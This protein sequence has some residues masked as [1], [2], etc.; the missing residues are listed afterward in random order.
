MT[1]VS[2]RAQELCESRGCRL[3]LPVPNNFYGLC[4]RKTTLNFNSIIR[5]KTAGILQR[6]ATKRV[7]SAFLSFFLSFF[8]CLFCS[9]VF[10][11]VVQSD[12]LSFQYPARNISQRKYRNQVEIV[13][14]D[15]FLGAV[16]RGL[17]VNP[18]RQA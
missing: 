15:R 18:I 2:V 16:Q 8:P 4:G 9:V 12:G 6:K 7:R 11:F 1:S 3:G 10:K 5:H 14:A 17:P 13:S